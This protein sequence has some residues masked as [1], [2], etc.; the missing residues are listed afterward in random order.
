[1]PSRNYRMK[2]IFA[3]L[4]LATHIVSTSCMQQQR[5]KIH[6][7]APQNI[8]VC[9]A[10]ELGW[11]RYD[12]IMNMTYKRDKAIAP[13]E[14]ELTPIY[15]PATMDTNNTAST[16]K[17][18]DE[19]ERKPF[20]RTLIPVQPNTDIQQLYDNAFT[21]IKNLSTKTL[22]T[23]IT[24]MNN[25]KNKNINEDV[26]GKYS[27]DKWLDK[28]EGLEEKMVLFFGYLKRYNTK[29]NNT[30]EPLPSNNELYKKTSTPITKNQLAQILDLPSSANTSKTYYIYDHESVCSNY[31][32]FYKL[33]HASKIYWNGMTKNLLSY[34]YSNK[35]IPQNDYSQLSYADL[36][37]KFYKLASCVICY[38]KY[39]EYQELTGSYLYDLIKIIEIETTSI[40]KKQEYDFVY[41]L[42]ELEPTAT[43]KLCTFL[44]F[45]AS[46]LANNALHTKKCIG[47]LCHLIK[48]YN[49]QR[50]NKITPTSNQCKAYEE[51]R[52]YPDFA[53]PD[54]CDNTLFNKEIYALDE[55]KELVNNIQ[56]LVWSSDENIQECIDQLYPPR[57]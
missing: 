42:I 36:K 22:I 32:A 4:L 41:D 54:S 44:N 24:D 31:P 50:K 2:K 12:K 30:K 49:N 18:C 46:I 25:A 14:I 56:I 45:V 19:K 5:P 27:Y 33:E 52:Y 43:E 15:R 20:L 17:Q 28:Q 39:G 47:I 55:F 11:E 57:K 29:V 21:V 40:P 1:M 13:N 3:F 9:E 38:T 26:M 34:V 37:D 51:F 48:K 6:Q 7:P 35:E 10:N 8:P 53:L 16:K 23:L